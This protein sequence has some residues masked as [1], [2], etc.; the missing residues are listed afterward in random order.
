M[1]VSRREDDT[2]VVSPV[3]VMDGVP[4]AP[5]ATVAIVALMFPVI[6]TLPS[7]VRLPVPVQAWLRLPLTTDVSAC[8]C[9]ITAADSDVGERHIT[10][11]G[12]GVAKIDS[13][14]AKRNRSGKVGI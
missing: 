3:V 1:D 7:D 12:S 10:Q 8:E 5:A 4:T 6:A 2:C 13:S 9:D 11:T 14:I